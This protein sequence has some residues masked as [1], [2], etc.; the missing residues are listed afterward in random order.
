MPIAIYENYDLDLEIFYTKVKLSCLGIC[1][2][3]SENYFSETIAACDLKVGRYIETK[4]LNEATRMSKVR[5]I[6]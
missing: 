6:I 5:I 1:M 3:K 2:I 4:R